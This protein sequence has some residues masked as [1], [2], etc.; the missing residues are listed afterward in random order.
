MYPYGEEQEDEELDVE[1]VRDG[2]CVKIDYGNG[3]YFYDVKRY[4]LFVSI[5]KNN[6]V[7][8]CF[9]C[10]KNCVVL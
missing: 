6:A 5:Y 9:N 3:L 10:K 7:S 4:K 2:L 8:H 1:N